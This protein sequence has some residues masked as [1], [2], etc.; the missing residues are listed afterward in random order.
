MTKTTYINIHSAVFPLAVYVWV[1]KNG[2]F[3]TRL[4]VLLLL[5][6]LLRVLVGST[7][8]CTEASEAAAAANLLIPQFRDDSG[9]N[10]QNL[11]YVVAAAKIAPYHSFMAL[12]PINIDTKSLPWYLLG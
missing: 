10:C 9:E 11:S 2:V 8:I 4:P 5:L 6:L 7:F 1:Y 12:C 3:S